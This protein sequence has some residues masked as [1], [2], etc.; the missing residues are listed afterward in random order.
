MNGKIVIS[1]KFYFH[2]FARIS[3]VR[4]ATLLDS[5]RS[6]HPSAALSA[7]CSNL[8]RQPTS[9]LF[10]TRIVVKPPLKI[11]IVTASGNDTLVGTLYNQL[12]SR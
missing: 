12:W 3:S 9:T 8:S 5:R 7:E 2:Q 10:T 6:L 1:M 11:D 4:S